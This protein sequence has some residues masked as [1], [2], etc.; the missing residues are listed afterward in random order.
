MNFKI[1]EMMSSETWEDSLENTP[2][3]PSKRQVSKRVSDAVDDDVVDD[4]SGGLE[5][6]SP[7]DPAK[8]VAALAPSASNKRRMATATSTPVATPNA[9]LA[10][11]TVKNENAVAAKKEH[12]KSS[13]KDAAKD[14]DAD[15]KKKKAAPAPASTASTASTAKITAPAAVAAPTNSNAPISSSTSN[16]SSS[17]SSK[18]SAA[19]SSSSGYKK[20]LI[21]LFSNASEMSSPPETD[22]IKAQCEQEKALLKMQH[23]AQ[24]DSYERQLLELTQ[25]LDNLKTEHADVVEERDVWKARCLNQ[26]QKI[27]Q[28]EADAAKV[29]KMMAQHQ[30]V[31]GN[32]FYNVRE[33]SFCPQF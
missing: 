2:I 31:P 4:S 10:V 18:S 9:K 27:E 19:A 20:K 26:K 23:K 15:K 12:K 22:T 5:V 1:S 17:S 33:P 30:Y 29:T 21:R 3:K 32:A 8:E 28:L 6:G 25:K 11:V 7:F 16:S 13:A 14:K 24:C